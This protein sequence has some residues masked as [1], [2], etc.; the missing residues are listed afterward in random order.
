MAKLKSKGSSLRVVNAL[1]LYFSLL[2]LYLIITVSANS[3]VYGTEKVDE[4][5]EIVVVIGMSLYLLIAN[6]LLLNML[7]A[8][9]K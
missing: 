2:V 7:I 3:T 9:F 1:I 4:A 5:T 6:V 8:V